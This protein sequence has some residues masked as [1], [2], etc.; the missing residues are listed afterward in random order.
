MLAGVTSARDPADRH[1]YCGD[2]DNLKQKSFNN[3]S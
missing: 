1:G 2:G 3:L